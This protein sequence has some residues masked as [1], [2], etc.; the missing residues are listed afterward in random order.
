[1]TPPGVGVGT[2]ANG[3]HADKGELGDVIGQFL[4][5]AL[6]QAL[7]PRDSRRTPLQVGDGAAPADH[8]HFAEDEVV[9]GHVRSEEVPQDGQEVPPQG[10][11]RLSHA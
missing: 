9:F 11:D 2:L 3:L 10:R 7:Q 6:A 8:A 5:A 1:L 4:D